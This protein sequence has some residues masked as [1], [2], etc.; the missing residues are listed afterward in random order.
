M[1][2]GIAVALPG[3][4]QGLKNMLGIGMDR[5]Q[6]YQELVAIIRNGEKEDFLKTIDKLEINDRNLSAVNSEIID[7][8]PHPKPLTS[9]SA[10]VSLD[11][12]NKQV[13]HQ[14]VNMIDQF[15]T[16]GGAKVDDGSIMRELTGARDI[17]KFQAL[18]GND[19]AEGSVILASY[20]QGFNTLATGIANLNAEIN[21]LE[22]PTTDVKSEASKLV[23]ANADQIK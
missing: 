4:Q 19:A 23:E 5:R 12:Q 8:K 16:S 15:L 10:D 17:A 13:M 9:D 6:A 22:N 18:F 2:G 20:L 1:G 7:G 14:M 21:S 11:A 3:F